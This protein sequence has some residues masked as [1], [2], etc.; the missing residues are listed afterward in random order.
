MAASEKILIIDDETEFAEMLQMR[1]EA[2]GYDV[3]I[4][5]DGESGLDLAAK[6]TADIILLDVMMPGMDGLAVLRKLRKQDATR[7]TPVIMLTAKGD[8][9]SIFEAQ[10]SG[11]NEY[12]IKP[13]DADR[14]DAL[15]KK[16]TGLR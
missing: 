9:K 12:I 16:H 8:T 11:A 7:H 1:L 6:D 3:N 4:A 5:C 2:R 10:D 15:I 13:C 14:L